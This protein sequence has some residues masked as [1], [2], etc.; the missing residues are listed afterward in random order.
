MNHHNGRIHAAL[1]GVAQFGAEHATALGRLKL[2]G[3]MQQ[4]G[5]HRCGHFAVGSSVGLC[6][7][8]PHGAQALA[9]LCRN[10]VQRSKLQ[11]RQT[12]LNR[13]QYQLALVAINR[14]PFIN[15]QHH[16]TARFEYVACNVRVLVRYALRGIKQQQHNVG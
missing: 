4:A 15:R 9:L 5:K 6:N 11:K 13:A 14:I 12:R 10:I 16:S 7:S 3:F 2:H 8:V 1:V